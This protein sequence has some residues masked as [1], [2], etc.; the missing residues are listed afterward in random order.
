MVL[1]DVPTD[2]TQEGI[3]ALAVLLQN[4]H[5]SLVSVHRLG[6]EI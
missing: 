3:L 4:I 5:Q 1:C 2:V 6:S